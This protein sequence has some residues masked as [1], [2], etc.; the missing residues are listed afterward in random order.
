MSGLH[1]WKSLGGFATPS[2][3]TAADVLEK[4]KGSGLRLAGWTIARTILIAPP[5]MLIGIPAKQAFIGAGLASGLMSIF[6][7][8]RI[9]DVKHTGLAGSGLRG[10]RRRRR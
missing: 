6:V 9:F 2:Y 7:L 1:G 5:F 8:L 3:K 4:D 10:A